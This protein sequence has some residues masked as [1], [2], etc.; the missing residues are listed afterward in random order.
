MSL[1]ELMIQELI[2]KVGKR[3]RFYDKFVSFKTIHVSIKIIIKISFILL[4]DYTNILFIKYNLIYI[5]I[6][7]I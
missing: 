2:P 6:D 5:I 7:Y 4:K 1:T 3:S